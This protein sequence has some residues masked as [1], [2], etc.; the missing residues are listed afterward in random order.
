MSD[1]I[2]EVFSGPAGQAEVLY[3]RFLGYCATRGYKYLVLPLKGFVDFWPVG[4]GPDLDAMTC[5]LSYCENVSMLGI[6]ADIM[7]QLA[8]FDD[9][10]KGITRLWYA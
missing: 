2:D 1:G 8:K 7:T 9:Y 4:L 5:N 10:G 6:W 3:R